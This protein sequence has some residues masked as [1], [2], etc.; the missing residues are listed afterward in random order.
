MLDN[1]FISE[2]ERRVLFGLAG[3]GGLGVVLG[4]YLDAGRFWPNFLANSFYFLTLA[5]GAVV[6]VSIQHLSNA[7]WSVALRRI[8]EAMMA[9][10][11]FGAMAMLAVFFGRHSIYEWTHSDIVQASSMLRAKATF[12]NTPFFFTRMAV[13]LSVWIF[14]AWMLRRESLRQDEDQLLDHTARSKRYAGMFMV[15]FAI[16]FSLA[17]FDWVMSVEPE[18]YSTIFAFYCFSGLFVTGIAAITLLVL[19]L[20]KRGFLPG[21]NESHLHMLGKLVFGFSTFWAYIWLCQYLL[22]YYTNLPEETIYYL[23]R[24]ADPIWKVVFLVNILLNWV[25]PFVL[26]LSRKAKQSPGWLMAACATVLVGH[27]VDVYTMVLPEF[28]RSPR[29]GLIELSLILGFTSVF[30]LLF[31]KSLGKASLQ[32]IFDPYLKESLSLPSLEPEEAGV[33]WSAESKRAL[34]FSTI[35]FAISF[36]VWGLI[37]ALAPRF[38]EMYQ[39][40]AVQTSLLIAIPVLLGSIGRIPMGILADRFGGR[41]VFG[42]LLVFCLIP[43]LG[44]GSTHS[45]G[46]LVAWGFLLGFAGTSFSVGVA[47]TSKWF[48][49]HQQGTALGIY[50]MGNVGQSVAMFAAPAMVAASGNWRLPFWTFGAV[51]GLF[52]IIFLLF[53][54]NSAVKAQPKKFMESLRLLK[55]EK[56]SWVLS[57]F[58]FL[59]F[60]GFV[61]LSIY[62]PTLLKDIFKLTM[63][64]AG[65]RVAGFVLVATLMRPVGGWLADRY[66]G[67]QILVFVF[68]LIACFALGLTSSNMFVFT[69]GALGTAALLGT[70][71]GA[72]FKLVPEYFPKET[73]TITGLVGAAGGLGGFFPPLVLGV[74]RSR[75]GSYTLGFI[76]LAGF[77]L[78]CLLINHLVFQRHREDEGEVYAMD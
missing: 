40:S 29:M 25:I 54:R 36:A 63:T 66:G 15:V 10:L 7:G 17:S 31:L 34:V 51:A 6:F 1:S 53:A 20:R 38:R 50:G 69:C 58:Y 59:T 14:F 61:A 62:L 22:I 64:D 30:L 70:G 71:N 23:R 52:G 13:M 2:R 28:L 56:L 32:P 19:V 41:V 35:A 72:V 49:A 37:G 46:K 42:A 75:T 24:T 74:I 60:G 78:L 65:A 11:P 45:Y 47:F 4:L 43:A 26:L 39:L 48:Q 8:P 27:W 33:T 16:T 9:Y 68:G 76:C 3:L 55:R 57:L 18:F 67:S 77:S 12:L 44:V 5:L 21:V 73:G